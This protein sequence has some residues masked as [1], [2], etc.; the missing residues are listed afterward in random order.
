MRLRQVF[1]SQSTRHTGRVL[2]KNYLSFLDFTRNY[3]RTSGILV[4]WFNC[5]RHKWSS[6]MYPLA[7]EIIYISLE[8][9]TKTQKLIALANCLN[10]SLP[11]VIVIV[12]GYTRNIVYYVSI[13]DSNEIKPVFVQY[14]RNTPWHFD[15]VAITFDWCMSSMQPTSY[16]FYENDAT[17]F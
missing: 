11:F 13:E 6:K 12:T 3:E 14:V 7:T 9:S 10:P 8:Y 17:Y 4:T 2:W 1:A 16:F 15:V 5:F